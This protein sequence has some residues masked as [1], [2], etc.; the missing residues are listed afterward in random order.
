VEK[1]LVKAGETQW[2]NEGDHWK[3]VPMVKGKTTSPE[4]D[5]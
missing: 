1:W 5:R 3:G 2:L 4:S